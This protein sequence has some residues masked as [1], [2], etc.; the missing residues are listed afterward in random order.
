MK[1]TIY[2]TAIGITLLLNISD[3]CLAQY[4]K[5]YDFAGGT[6]GSHPWNTNLIS[7]GTYLYGMTVDAGVNSLGNIFKVLPNGTG[8]TN[9]FDFS[10]ADGTYP[11]GSLT[12]DGG[13]GYLYGMTNGG[14]A[15]NLGVIFKI[16]PDGTGYT[17]LLDFAG[18]SNGSTPYGNLIYDGTFLYGMTYNGGT[19]NKGTIFKIKPDG[20]GYV[21]LLNFAGAANGSFPYGSLVYDGTYLYGMTEQGG[22]NFK[23]VIFKIKP[24]GTGYVRL[25]SFAG[26][27]NGSYTHGS[28]IYDGAS[29]FLFGMTYNGGANSVGTVFKILTDGTGYVNLLDF[30][31]A[32]NGAYPFGTPVYDG[33]FLY[34]FTQ[35]GGANSEGN[36]FKIKPDGSGFSDLIDFTGA[37]G[38]YPYGSPVLVGNC[39]YGM[40]YAG[41]VNGIGAIF[42]YGSGCSS[43]PVELL[44]FNANPLNNKTVL[45]QWV[46]SSEINNDHF[47]VQRSQD[48]Q[49][50][51]DVGKVKGAGT[52]SM[53]HSYMLMD[54]Q[55]YR[56][57]SYYRLKQVDFSSDYKYYGPVAVK[58]EGLEIVTLF[59]NP[60]MDHTDYTVISSVESRVRITLTDL[61]GRNIVS[62]SNNLHIGENHLNIAMG[63]FATG[64]YFLQLITETGMY[65]AQKQVVVK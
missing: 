20:T 61:L 29:G 15:N 8:Y 23:G 32:S 24:D 48:G 40:T 30:A 28:L 58:L 47:L 52:S 45:T 59:P 12:Y 50:W 44:S 34:G 16:R 62:E 42:S 65:R 49:N 3:P 7:D 56:G 21:R 13:T 9:L 46:T 41:G 17:D 19:G 6:A 63:E 4:T 11:Q 27:T 43:L 37:I 31:G 54:E 33:T 64:S 55:P 35:G 22:A 2:T 57:T 1:K 53:Q 36:L 39:L 5:V 14:G 18:A 26:A 38:S 60:T 10:W 25:L 51:E